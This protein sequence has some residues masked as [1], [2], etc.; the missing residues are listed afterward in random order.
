MNDFFSDADDA[1]DAGFVFSDSVASA[2]SFFVSC[3]SADA[4]VPVGRGII[5]NMAIKD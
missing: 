1:D 5:R 3:L 2:S 4:P